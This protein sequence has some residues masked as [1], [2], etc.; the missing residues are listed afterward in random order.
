MSIVIAVTAAA[1]LSPGASF[2][3]MEEG[4][5][6]ELVLNTGKSSRVQ[7]AEL[8]DPLIHFTYSEPG[9]AA[10]GRTNKGK[11]DWLKSRQLIDQ[12]HRSWLEREEKEAQRKAD[13]EK[14]AQGL[15][16]VILTDG[17]EG[18]QPDQEVDLACDARDMAL[19]Q[20]DRRRAALQPPEDP[21]E[22]PPGATPADPIEGTPG[23]LTL[24]GPDILLVLAA[25]AVVAVLVKVMILRRDA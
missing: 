15:T 9:N 18:W 25:L 19:A 14:I 22:L 6:W 17:S 2:D 8:K 23:F 21:A 12:T 24:W 3:D 16:R 4:Q 10:S 1:L 13:A 7:I 11:I 5:Y 20:R